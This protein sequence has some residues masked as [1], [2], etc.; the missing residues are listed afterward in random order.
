MAEGIERAAR[1]ERFLA[2]RGWADARRIPLAGDASFR[3]Y[4]R[5]RRGLRR[6]VLMDAPPGHEDVRPYLRIARHLAGLGYSA[7]AI[8]AEDAEAG[9]LLVEDLGDA[10][11]TRLLAADGQGDAEE[12]YG[13]AIDLL[14]DLHRKPAPPGLG[15]Y[16]EALYL[17]EAD[18]LLDWY[19]PAVP[20]LPAPEPLRASYHH[21]WREVLPRAALGR[22][23]LVLRDY[24][25]DNLMWLAARRGLARVGLLDFQDALAGSPAYDVVSLLEDCRR[26]VPPELAE[27]MIARYLDAMAEI[28]AAAFRASYAVLGAQRN[29]KIVGIFTRLWR[30]DAKSAYLGLIPTVWRLLE[31]DLAHPALDPVREWFDQ[32]VP[33]PFRRA[34]VP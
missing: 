2:G 34:P 23:V 3:R 4:E 25:A 30:R 13:A 10:S 12:L 27:R 31:R 11:F 17:A 24:H 5:L 8:H 26:D 18:L 16:D 22:S 20:G 32:H 1:I 14:A 6:A 15:A 21:V 29:A 9:L 28:D 7:P 33:P 19:L